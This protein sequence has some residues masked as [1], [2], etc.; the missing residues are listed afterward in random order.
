MSGFHRLPPIQYLTA[1]VAV[2]RQGSFKLAAASLN[3]TPSAI[4]QQ[5]KTLEACVGLRLFS[6][7][8]KNIELTNAGE[9]LYQIAE[10]TISSYEL[11][12]VDFVE[13][14]LSSSLK[15]ST[16][17]YIANELLIPQLQNFHESYPEL[18][19]VVEATMQIQDLEFRGLDAAIRFGIPPWG[20]E[21]VELIAKAH[22]NLVA[23]EEYLHKHPIQK[24][25][26]WQHQTLIHIRTNVNDWQRFKN[27]AKLQFTPKRELFF[28][29]YDAGIRAAEEGLG[30]AIG[31]FPLSNRKISAGQLSVLSDR[32]SS[33]EEAFY[34][35]TK[36][37]EYKN[38]SY[39]A[40]LHW[41]KGVFGETTKAIPFDSLKSELN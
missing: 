24:E 14:Y 39:G 1:F 7:Q 19:L 40:L 8:T 28:D 15:I 2:V 3:V 36:Q 37:N 35:V 4:S 18:N 12:Y 30:I 34:L 17:P 33:I 26:D 16:T 5:I 41:L 21:V 6:R 20:G 25:A 38:E 31:V 27:Y 29:S 13:Q 32:Y 9:S 11:G 23:S 10:K 22:S